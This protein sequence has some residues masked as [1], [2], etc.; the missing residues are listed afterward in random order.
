MVY[1]QPETFYNLGRNICISI[2]DVWHKNPYTR[3][4]DPNEQRKEIADK[5]AKLDR[6][7]KEQ[8]GIKTKQKKIVELIETQFYAEWHKRNVFQ[9]PINNNDTRKNERLSQKNKR[10]EKSITTDGP[11]PHSTVSANPRQLRNQFAS[12]K[13]MVKEERKIGSVQPHIESI[14]NLPVSDA[15]HTQMVVAL[16]THVESRGLFK[17]LNMRIRNVNMGL[18]NR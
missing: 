17:P 14:K 16:K 8:A 18:G 10:T 6:F 12:K 5:Q 13:P 11:K 4:S 15:N 3:I 1:Y 2:L 9:I 7:K